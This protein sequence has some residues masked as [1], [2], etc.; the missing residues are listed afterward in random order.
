MIY[1]GRVCYDAPLSVSKKSTTL[2]RDKHNHCGKAL[3]C[4]FPPTPPF[5]SKTGSAG[6]FASAYRRFSLK[7]SLR[8]RMSACVTIFCFLQTEGVSVMTRPYF[9]LQNIFDLHFYGFSRY[10]MIFYDNTTLFTKKQKHRQT[11]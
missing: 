8:R 5:Q 9:Y 1:A 7:E 2:S 10:F 6:G 3:F 11:A 4:V